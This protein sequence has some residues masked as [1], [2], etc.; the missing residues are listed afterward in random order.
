MV[1]LLTIFNNKTGNEYALDRCETV[2]PPMMQRPKLYEFSNLGAIQAFLAEQAAL[3]PTF[4]GVVIRDRHNHRWKIKSA[5]YLGL[6]RLRGEGD[7]LFNPKNLLPFVLAGEEDELLTYFPEVRLPYYE[8]KSRV[9]QWYIN[10]LEVW[11]EHWTIAEQKEFALTIKDRTPFASLLFDVRKRLGNK[12]SPA[13]LR[14]AWRE[15]T[16]LILK[17]L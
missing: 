17:R 6:H 2:A 12:Q 9:Q 16:S 5:T 10:L 13:D 15:S 1:Y 8:L 4:E 14:K 7:N 3:D 11:A